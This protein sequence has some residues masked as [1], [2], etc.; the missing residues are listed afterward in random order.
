MEIILPEKL[1]V[2]IALHHLSVSGAHKESDFMREGIP[3]T[4]QVRYRLPVSSIKAQA[5]SV[6]AS[7]LTMVDRKI[8]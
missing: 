3:G 4:N 5:N 2:N 8:C 7:H 6:Y 1:N